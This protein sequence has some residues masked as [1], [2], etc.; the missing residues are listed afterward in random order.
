MS[1]PFTP[2]FDPAVLPADY[3]DVRKEYE[4]IRHGAALI[5]FSPA[6]KLRLTGKNAI[7]FLNGLVSNDVKTLEPYQGVFACFPNLQG[8][9]AALTV[10]YHTEQ[11]L[12]IELD[13]SNRE[14]IFKNLSRF[15]PAGEFFLTDVTEELALFSLQGPQAVT[16]L[17]AA[18]SKPIEYSETRTLHSFPIATVEIA[19]RN[20]TGGA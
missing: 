9:V 11:G 15:V 12:L 10:I 19:T 3:G 18:A 2:Q 4:T 13:A 8:K 1:S 17:S 16:V 7:Q 5:D 6:A 20:R 14:K